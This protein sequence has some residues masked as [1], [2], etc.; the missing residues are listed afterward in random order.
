MKRSVRLCICYK[1]KGSGKNHYHAGGLASNALHSATVLRRAGVDVDLLQVEDF[2]ALV[3]HLDQNPDTTH[4]VVEAVWMTTEQT[5]VLAI[6]HSDKR[7]VVRAHSKMGFLQVEPEAVT[8][9]REIVEFGKVQS[10]LSFSSNNAEFASSI[11]YVFGPCLYLPNLYDLEGAPVGCVQS[12][13]RLRIASFGASRLLKLHPSAALAALQIAESERMPLDFFI[14]ADKT[15]G[16]ESVRK[17]VR[18]LFAGLPNA[19]LVEVGWQD[20]DKFKETIASMDLVLQMS[21]TETFCMVAADAVASGVP[22]VVGPAISWVA[23]KWQ[24]SIDDTSEVAYIGI[25]ALNS[26]TVRCSQ[27][28]SLER[29][30]SESRIEWV[31]FLGLK[32]KCRLFPW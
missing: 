11:T 15:P 7:I 3:R 10:N 29:H 27:K 1:S 12:G 24:V 18:A 13:D 8:R 22:V 5:K 19:Q 31:N 21:A 9:M 25:K 2:A 17:T 26:C 4:V 28:S 14:N 6:S 32:R 20:A 30:V 23:K 16:G